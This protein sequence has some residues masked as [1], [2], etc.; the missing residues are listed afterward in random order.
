MTTRICTK[1]RFEKDIA[2]FSWSIRGIKRH[3]SCNAC[4]AEERM[5]YYERNKEKELK[6]KGERQVRKKEEARQFVD[7][8]K[9]IHPCVDCGNT[10]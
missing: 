3:S 2:E 10:E 6:Y 7:A 9:S 4:R 5:D 8:Y 1:C